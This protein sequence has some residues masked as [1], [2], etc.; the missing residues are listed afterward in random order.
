MSKKPIEVLNL[1]EPKL[2]NKL[3]NFLKGIV[4]KTVSKKYGVVFSY[5][6][7]KKD[8]KNKQILIISDHSCRE[9]YYFTL[10]GLPFKSVN[11]IVSYQNFFK[12]TLAKFLMK[13]GC[14]PKF[15]FVPDLMTIKNIFNL[16]KKGASFLLFPEGIQSICGVN[17]PINPATFKLIK[18]LEMD[19]ILCSSK[20]SF[21][22]NNRYSKQMIKGRLEVNY[23]YLFT[24]EE[25]SKLSEEEIRKKILENFRYN[26]FKWNKEHGYKYIGKL[27]NAYNLESILYHCPKCHKDFTMKSEKDILY[28]TNCGNKIKVDESYNIFPIGDS[29]LPFERIDNWYFYEREL[30]KEEIKKN[31]FKIKCKC[32]YVVLSEEKYLSYPYIT[33]GNGT[34]SLTKEKIKYNGTKN[35][36]HFEIDFDI[37]RIPSISFSNRNDIEFYY[38]N[39][40]YSF[41]MTEDPN[42]VL[43]ITIAVQEL[44]NLNDESWRQAWE[45]VKHEN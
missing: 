19:T 43:K 1:Y 44:H 16:K 32:S 17:E 24:K 29:I 39:K 12:K 28:C 5:D 31:N 21:L 11:A 26:D 36:K 8:I 27:P 34:F 37:K 45:D 38:D 13:M 42:I 9:Q 35:G 14:I 41:L 18:K 20:G 3:I 40:Y 22:T 33:I 23:K 2:P 30:I 10:G 15:L 4:A 7:D 6:F 25:I